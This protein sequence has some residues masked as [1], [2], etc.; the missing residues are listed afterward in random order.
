MKVVNDIGSGKFIKELFRKKWIKKLKLIKKLF[1][2]YGLLGSSIMQSLYSWET[3]L[4]SGA[5]FG[6][7]SLKSQDDYWLER[8]LEKRSEKYSWTT[9]TTSIL[10]MRTWNLIIDDTEWFLKW[11]AVVNP[12]SIDNMEFKTRADTYDNW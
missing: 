3:T 1:R 4:K 8:N 6:T 9:I 5:N 11:T 10:M 7:A 12:I 2:H